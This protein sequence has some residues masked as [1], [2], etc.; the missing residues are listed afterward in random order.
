VTAR[1]V[2]SFARRALAGALGLGLLLPRTAAALWAHMTDDELLQRSD[3]VVLGT[4]AGP[5]EMGLSSAP[6]E[7]RL[8]VGAVVAYEVFKGSPGQTLALVVVPATDGPRRS[9][10]L[11]YRPG[12]RGLWLLRRRP[13]I[14]SGLYLADHPQ[15]FVPEAT[16]AARIRELRKALGRP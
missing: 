5:T 7:S 11:V 10:D 13:G 3:L 16:G 14:P 1:G 4:W 2:E 9:T 15:R 8:N 6:T 12:D